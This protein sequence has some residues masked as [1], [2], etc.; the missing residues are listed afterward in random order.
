MIQRQTELGRILERKFIARV[1]SEESAEIDQEINSKMSGFSDQTNRGRKFAVKD[2][3]LDYRFPMRNRFID[4]RHR[5]TDKGRIKKKRH[6]V[7]NNI[8]FG[9]ANN[10]VQRISYGFTQE[11]KEEMMKMHNTQI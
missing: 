11:V 1:L 7:H 10:M 6:K 8:L 2:T 9:Y 5:L 4:M 3:T